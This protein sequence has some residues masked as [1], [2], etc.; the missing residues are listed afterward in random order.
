LK[1][2]GGKVLRFGPPGKNI[3]KPSKKP[4]DPP[5]S[6]LPNHKNL[7]KK[8]S[9]TYTPIQTFQICP[10]SYIKPYTNQEYMSI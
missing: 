10:L 6:S 4:H 9:V 1:V 5:F 7:F 2:W 3:K 8:I